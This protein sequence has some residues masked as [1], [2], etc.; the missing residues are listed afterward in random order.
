MTILFIPGADSGGYILYAT[1]DVAT[2]GDSGDVT[3]STT[4]PSQGLGFLKFS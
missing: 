3:F 4:R 2:G 1:L